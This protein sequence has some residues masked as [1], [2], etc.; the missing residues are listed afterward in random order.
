MTL[1]TTNALVWAKIQGFGYWPARVTDANGTQ[2]QIYTFG[3]HLSIWIEHSALSAFCVGEPARQRKRTKMFLAAVK[4]AN[5]VASGPGGCSPFGQLVPCTTQTRRRADDWSCSDC[6]LVNCGQA[7]KSSACGTPRSDRKWACHYCTF[8]NAEDAVAC[9]ACKSSRVAP[10]LATSTSTRVRTLLNLRQSARGSVEESI[11]QHSIAQPC[12]EEESALATVA[13]DAQPTALSLS[14][15]LLLL[16]PSAGET[17]EVEWH[18]HKDARP[19]RWYRG[20]VTSGLGPSKRPMIEYDD[21]D[22]AELG[23]DDR[24]RRPN[25]NNPARDDADGGAGVS[26]RQLRGAEFGCGTARLAKAAMRRG[27]EM[28]TLD[29]DEHAPEYEDGLL[30]RGGANHWV[31]E[32][33]AVQ[34]EELPTFDWLH[35]S[36]NC[37][38]TSILAASKHQR[39]FSTSFQGTTVECQLWNDDMMTFYDIV[40]QQRRRPGNSGCTFTVEQPVGLARSTQ[41]IRLFETSIESGGLGAV[42]CTFDACRHGASCKKP[43]DLWVGGLDGL[44]HALGTDRTELGYPP[45]K[46][47]CSGHAPCRFYPQHPEVRGNTK[48]TCAFSADLCAFLLAHIE[49]D[50]CASRVV[51]KGD[52]L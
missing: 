37:A 6:T 41:A 23:V 28:I 8:V 34:P 11:W 38:S 5:E 27:F 24:W 19:T 43:T 4:E 15:G 18:P 14:S 21:G 3:D 1:F 10:E 7:K 50:L 33:K 25:A 39:T 22:V 51:D 32:L 29:R 2:V 47:R 17:I 52:K 49:A 13:D 48:A 42:R 45:P 16:P 12:N 31:R 40:K 44:I 46:W 36:P 35:F 30:P 9:L 26:T 20:H